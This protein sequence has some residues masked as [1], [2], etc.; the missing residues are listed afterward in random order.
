M[1]IYKKIK[2]LLFPNKCICCSRILSEYATFCLNCFQDIN[3]G[4][5]LSKCQICSHPFEYDAEDEVCVECQTHPPHFDKALYLYE[6]NK[7]Y[8]KNSFQN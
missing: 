7:I 8:K 6:Y 1:E 5:Y 3:G 2:N 4:F